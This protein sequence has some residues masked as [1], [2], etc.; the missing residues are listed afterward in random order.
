MARR[1]DDLP[2]IEVE[3]LEGD[4]GGGDDTMRAVGE[5]AADD[6]VGGGRQGGGRGRVDAECVFCVLLALF[7]Y[8]L[9]KANKNLTTFHQTS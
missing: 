9:D 8:Y 7:T 4:K 1:K 5:T 2:S 6:G 3:R